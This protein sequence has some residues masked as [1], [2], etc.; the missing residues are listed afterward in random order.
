MA[1]VLLFSQVSNPYKQALLYQ[2]LNS[3]TISYPVKIPKII[4]KELSMIEVCWK[5]LQSLRYS[6]HFFDEDNN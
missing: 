2:V 1:P 6:N 3:Q 4:Q 5:L